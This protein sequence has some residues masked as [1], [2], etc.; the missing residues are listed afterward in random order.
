MKLALCIPGLMFLVLLGMLLYK[1]MQIKP[2][3][4][5]LFP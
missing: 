2:A 3:T 5:M 4:A 1:F